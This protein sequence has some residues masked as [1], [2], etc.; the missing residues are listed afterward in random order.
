MTTKHPQTTRGGGT[1]QHRN[2]PQKQGETQPK[3]PQHINGESC[4]LP[5]AATCGGRPLS[6][7]PAKAEEED[8]DYPPCV[9][10]V[11]NSTASKSIVGPSNKEWIV[12][13]QSPS[14]LKGGREEKV[15]KGEGRGWPRGENTVTD[16][17]LRGY[18]TMASP[19]RSVYSP[20]TS[21]T[22]L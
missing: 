5:W 22:S 13:P 15:D 1:P 19:S 14:M 2:N 6:D 9:S 17:W 20:K 10:N 18:P 12:T 7:P 3:Q 4:C 16:G 8:T 21:Q 11:Q